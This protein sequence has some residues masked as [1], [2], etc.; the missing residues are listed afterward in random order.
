LTIN[1]FPGHMV[2]ARREME[3]QLKL[4]DIVLLVLDARAPF[5]CR[6]P[7]L[8]QMMAG[9][10]VVYVLNKSD[11]AEPEM[12]RAYLD[13]FK[14]RGCAACP[15][16]AR[17]GQGKKELLQ[18]AQRAYQEIAAG[19][20]SKGRRVRPAR[21]MVAGVPNVGKST[22]LNS[23][24]GKKVAATGE[25]PGVT[26]GRQWIRCLEQLELMDTPGLMWPKVDDE[27]QGYKLA[28]LNIVGSKAYS[29]REV[30]LYGLKRLRQL[31]PEVIRRH[32]AAGME[33]CTEEELLGKLAERR[34]F[35]NRGGVLD[36]EKA[37]QVLL[38][39]L[40]RG[41]WGRFGLDS[42]PMKG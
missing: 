5:S 34:G 10:E 32:I 15:L 40:R 19:M 35:I 8:E 39:E 31:H 12:T 16:D 2:K 22:A 24:A 18:A 29:E 1:W 26:R 9:K 17:S 14:K 11:L 36:T 7:Q 25:K 30:A 27:E 4:V 13:A 38:H 28:L 37:A 42:A 20:L 3:E 21:L 41:K 33:T 6:N 23:I